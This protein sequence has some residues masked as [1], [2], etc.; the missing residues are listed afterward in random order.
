MRLKLDC[1]IYLALKQ[2]LT[3]EFYFI[4][5]QR[6]TNSFLIFQQKTRNATTEQRSKMS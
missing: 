6:K 4:E 1:S 2:Y 5:R 3:R